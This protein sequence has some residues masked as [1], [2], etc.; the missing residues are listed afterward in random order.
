MREDLNFK[1]RQLNDA[2]RTAA[3]LQVEVEA[4]RQDLNKYKHLEGTIKSQLEQ[5]EQSVAKMED[6]LANKF[7][8]TN[9]LSQTFQ[10]DKESMNNIKNMASQY[11]VGLTKQT[12]FHAMKHDT[13]KNQIYAS[14][15]YV[16]LNEQEKRLI[17]NES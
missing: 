8:K 10:R 13:R 9:E 6:E 1:Q 12:T 16:K 15:V 5:Y 7:P 3:Q 11:K 4:R 2:E 14:D 17:S